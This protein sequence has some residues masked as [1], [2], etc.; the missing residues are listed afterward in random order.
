M[1]IDKYLPTFDVRDY[2]EAHVVTDPAQTYTT[3][4]S[5]DL[6]DSR[7]VRILFAIRTIPLRFRDRTQESSA[8]PVGQPF[9]ETAL[10]MGWAELEEIPNQELVIGAVTQPWAPVVH[11][12]GLPALD[13]VAFSDPGFAKIVWNIAVR[14][15]ERGGTVVST[16]TRVAC[17]DPKSRRRFRRY[18]FVFGLGIRL[19]HRAAIKV[20]RQE[21][22]RAAPPH[23]A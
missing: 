19:I 17:T 4:R 21:L 18:W 8:A 7:I 16:E 20:L 14:P 13:F 23:A 15:D 22:E 9:L 5:L 1:L 10:A 11:F 6:T 2:H 12:Q 3:F